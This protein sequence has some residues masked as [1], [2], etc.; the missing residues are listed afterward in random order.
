MRDPTSKDERPAPD[1]DVAG[2]PS[3]MRRRLSDCARRIVSYGRP[4]RWPVAVGILV[5][6]GCHHQAELSR[7]HFGD[8]NFLLVLEAFGLCAASLLLTFY[9]WQWLLLRQ[10]FQVPFEEAFRLGVW[11]LIA[12]YAPMGAWTGTCVK[13]GLIAHR[14]ASRKFTAATTV[15]LDRL[16][17]ILGLAVLVVVGGPLP[18]A[19]SVYDHWRLVVAI[20][21]GVTVLGASVWVARSS[22]SQAADAGPSRSPRRT[23]LTSLRTVVTCVAISVLAQ[24]CMCSSIY[25]CA[26]AIPSAGAAPSWRSHLLLLPVLEVVSLVL[27]LPGGLGARE[28]MISGFYR[29]AATGTGTAHSVAAFGLSVAILHR[30]VVAVFLAA[31]FAYSVVRVRSASHRFPRSSEVPSDQHSRNRTLAAPAAEPIDRP[32]S[33]TL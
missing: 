33:E 20:T 24:V 19:L 17:G 16:F 28:S 8:L 3:R 30:I 27:P 25:L 1:Q 18:E 12:G 29:L 14:Q 13:G 21:G 9:R 31:G 23:T 32:I 5:W 26:V 10:G 11:G 15:V 22:Q 2:G 6:L 7:I 4:L